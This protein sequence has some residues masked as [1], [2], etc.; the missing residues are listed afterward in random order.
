MVEVGESLAVT[1]ARRA[2][3]GCTGEVVWIE[4]RWVR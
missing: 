2:S 4:I 1:V 3:T